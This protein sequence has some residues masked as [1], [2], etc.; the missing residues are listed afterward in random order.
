MLVQN[1]VKS[2]KKLHPLYQTKDDLINNIKKEDK[3]ILTAIKGIIIFGE[4]VITEILR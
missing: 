4:N 1:R 2:Q 3:I